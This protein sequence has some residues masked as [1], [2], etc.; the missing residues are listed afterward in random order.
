[1]L[2]QLVKGLS[3]KW[4][5]KLTALF[6]LHDKTKKTLIKK[7]YLIVRGFKCTLSRILR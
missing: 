7:I 1:M 5:T 4:D 2:R 6:K 3:Q